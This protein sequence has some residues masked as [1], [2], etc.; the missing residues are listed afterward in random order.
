MTHLFNSAS[1][2]ETLRL[3]RELGRTIKPPLAVLLYGEL[4]AGKTVL[5]RGIAEGL[6]VFDPALVRSPTFT[7]VNEYPSKSGVIYHIDLY[8]LETERDFSSIGL[9]ELLG[10]DA[11]VMVEWPEKLK[12]LPPIRTEIYLEKG[13]DPGSR[14]IRIDTRRSGR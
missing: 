12:V 7:L 14:T 10:K 1:E 13:Q 9:D 3:G 6:E 5:A 4:G 11:V 8:R 2:E